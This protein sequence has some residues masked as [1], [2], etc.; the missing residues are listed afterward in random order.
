M[1]YTGHISVHD[2]IEM[3]VLIGCLLLLCL[4]SRA[5]EVQYQTWWEF[6]HHKIV[7]TL[8]ENYGMTKYS[9]TVFKLIILYGLR[10]M[11]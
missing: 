6:I 8:W 9:R 4:Y 11:L 3:Y 1:R 7:N 5:R 10:R 2:R